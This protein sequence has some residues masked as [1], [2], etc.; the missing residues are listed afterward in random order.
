MNVQNRRKKGRKNLS[1]SR[2]YLAYSC[3][4][5]KEAKLKRSQLNLSASTNYLHKT[6]STQTLKAPK[7]DYLQESKKITTPILNRKRA[8]LSHNL[9]LK[10]PKINF[11]Q[12]LE[13]D[14]IER[15]AKW[16]QYLI[17]KNPKKGM[18]RLLQ[19]QEADAILIKAM[20]AKCMY[21]DSSLKAD[22]SH[23]HAEKLPSLKNI[24]TKSVKGRDEY[25]WRKRR[26]KI[27]NKAVDRIVEEY[28][29]KKSNQTAFS[30]PFSSA[31]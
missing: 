11:K 15:K 7:K 28:R 19:T 27:T 4:I 24:N 23:Q 1:K 5:G 16:K 6:I 30:K 13:V 26:Y 31:V 2:D 25:A 18:S 3:K 10:K 12:D 20:V 22:K 9:F 17:E 8:N 29:A 14:N 21:N